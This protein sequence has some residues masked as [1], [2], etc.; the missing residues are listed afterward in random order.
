[1][2]SALG[3]KGIDIPTGRRGAHAEELRWI[4]VA[5]IS[6]RADQPRQ[7][8][9]QGA[10]EE[11]VVS[12][13]ERGVLQPIRVRPRGQLFE[14]IAGERRWLAARRAGLDEIPA[15]VVDVD[16][17]QAYIEA[18]I[19]NI[20]RE[21][22]SAVDRAQ[23][24]KRLRSNLGSQSW[25]D[26][27][28]LIGISQRHVYHLLNLTRLPEQIQHDIRAGDL[29]EK[30]GRALVRLR[31]HPD[32]QFGL[33]QLIHAQALSGN[34]ALKAAR[35][36]RSATGPGDPSAAPPS[37]LRSLLQ[38]LRVTLT[39]SPMDEVLAHR[40]ELAGLHHWLGE[41]LGRVPREEPPTDRG[42]IEQP[43]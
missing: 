13:R 41:M 27:G 35:R 18:L 6:R 30:H 11:L 32:L 7:T 1:M 12:V 40:A 16:A 42:E 31:H 8:V 9:N 2:S 39:A 19:E 24:L 34:A 29:T 15:V 33:W 38:Q 5:L 43:M 10:L 37:Q 25:E 21:D 14:I 36:L 3:G 17:D 23:A 20:Q 4:P 28:R 26:V 22:L